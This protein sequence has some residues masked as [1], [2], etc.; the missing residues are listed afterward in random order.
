MLLFIVSA[1]IFIILN[2]KNLR[3]LFTKNFILMNIVAFIIF[4][5][6]IY[7]NYSNGFVS[8][9]HHKDISHIENVNFDGMNFLKF[10][11]TQFL[12][13]GPIFCLQFF[14][15]I[16]FIPKFIN[17]EH[18]KFL[19]SFSVTFFLVI[20]YLSIFNNAYGNWAAPAYLAATILV[21]I[22]LNDSKYKSLIKVGFTINIL[23]AC[24]IFFIKD[25]QIMASN[26][27]LKLAKPLAKFLSKSQN[28][29]EFVNEIT[30]ELDKKPDLPVIISERKLIAEILYYGGEDYFDRIKKL[31]F[32][33]IPKDHYD[34]TM[35][36]DLQNLRDE[37]IAIGRTPLM[38]REYFIHQKEI[39]AISR[40]GINYHITY[41]RK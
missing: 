27:E 5:P 20:L 36:L 16:I 37:Y 34:L 8:F 30:Y 12:I 18:Y 4:L 28:W 14:I 21:I 11:A 19:Y 9:M 26:H 1:A 31:S 10:L 25:L 39:A 38:F 29:Q 15:L 32:S 41:L 22:F 7:W 17:K 40:F 24:S 6:N 3:G 13:I 35:K 2:E 23:L 33:S